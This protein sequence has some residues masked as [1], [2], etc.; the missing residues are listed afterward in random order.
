MGG[1]L[2][3]VL[4]VLAADDGQVWQAEERALS[5]SQSVINVKPVP[6]SELY[7]LCVTAGVI[8]VAVMISNRV[9]G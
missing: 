8:P 2:G 1:R 6:R 4:A 7:Q 3:D 9:R 5:A